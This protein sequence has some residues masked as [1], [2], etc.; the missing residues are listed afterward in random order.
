VATDSRLE[1]FG[2]ETETGAIIRVPMGF[3]GQ[4]EIPLDLN[5]V[6]KAR[7]LERDHH[8]ARLSHRVV[9]SQAT[10]PARRLPLGEPRLLPGGPAPWRAVRG[11]REDRS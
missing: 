3:A 1:A 2:K 6:R 5:E 9:V 10:N 11:G 4:L 8:R 7:T